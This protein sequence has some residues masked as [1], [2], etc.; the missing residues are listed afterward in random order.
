MA[1]LN[2]LKSQFMA[3]Q[4]NKSSFKLSERTVVEIV[5]KIIDR[6]KVNLLH[7]TSGKE[8]VVD[9]KAN[10]EI[11]NEIKKRKRVTTFELSSYLEL[12]IGIIEK[13][14]DELINKNKNF[15]L[16]DGKIMTKEYLDKITQE[17]NDVV[18]KQGSASLADI[19]NKYDLSIDFLKNFLKEKISEGSLNAK[20]FPTR[21]ITD[22]YIQNQIKKIRPL[23]LANV[24][25]ISVS[26]ILSKYPDIDEL[27][28][29]QNIN[30]LIE[31]GQV[32][33]S[34]ISNQFEN[35]LY[36]KS[37]E[38]Y[39]LGELNQNNYIDFSKLKNIGINKNGDEFVKNLIKNEPNI[40]GIFLKDY[41]ITDNLKNNIYLIITDN[42]SK[43]LPTNLKENE[44]LVNLDEDDIKVLLESMELSD[45]DY[46]Y[47][48][49]NFIPMKLINDFIE[50]STKEVKS[51]AEKLFNECAKKLEEEKK[52]EDQKDSESPQ[53]EPPQTEKKKKKG[54]AGKS[55]KNANK[56]NTTENKY[57]AFLEIKY[58][59]TESE[60]IMNNFID[61]PSF[62]FINE[63]RDTL[64]DVFEDRILQELKSIF[65]LEI[66]TLIKLKEQQDNTVDVNSQLKLLN[67]SYAYLK[68]IKEN[69]SKVDNYFKSND[70]KRALKSLVTYLCKNEV[71]VFMKDLMIYEIAKNK[72]TIDIHKLESYAEREKILNLFNDHET[73]NSFTNLNKLGN[74]KNYNDFMEELDKYIKEK[75]IEI[76][77]DGNKEKEQ[78]SKIEND[79]K[80]LI[81][82]TSIDKGKKTDY[83]LYYKHIIYILNL[84]LVHK[85]LYFK[86]P[87]EYW[88]F[89][90]CKT[91]LNIDLFKQSNNFDFSFGDFYKMIE[92]KKENG[93]EQVFN[94][95]KDKFLEFEQQ[96][97]SEIK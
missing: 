29:D 96:F 41:F 65:D 89:S 23:L 6:G 21:I 47:S 18:N 91:I 90:V 72:L 70:E 68:L 74:E 12:P 30:T 28:I 45:Q 81:N 36:S 95:N 20:L 53:A 63:K 2:A 27:L 57:K 92:N 62:E 43:N 94:E 79:L 61:N 40:K 5:M 78:I 87:N 83:K 50:N 77:Y 97:K 58:P 66:R 76:S 93:L 48:N 32:K 9:G 15:L 10:I 14:V 52:E 25:P 39:V 19:S 37:Q 46:I 67:N 13:K 88:I 51:T 55:G 44:L 73:R 38:N 3:L 75:K 71:N 56:K 16:I 80:K 49:Y 8:Y 85:N 69:I 60:K 4:K 64:K 84:L 22:Y 7:T 34:L 11:I 82:D 26:K 31:S 42:E 86:L 24:N 59:R 17:I 54:G 1:D 33:G 35:S